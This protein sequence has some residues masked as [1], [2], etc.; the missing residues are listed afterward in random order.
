MAVYTELSDSEIKTLLASYALGEFRQLEGIAEG[1]EN[2]NFFLR[3]MR[4]TYILTIY[5][6]RVN[7]ED[8]PFFLTLM[9]HLASKH[10]PC[11]TPIADNQ[12]TLLQTV[13]GR[14]AAI[15]SFLA[16]KSTKNIRIHHLEALGAQL[17]AMHVAGKDFPLRRA[18]NFSLEC[19]LS[20]FGAVSSRA[21]EVKQGL[22]GEIQRQLDWLQLH[23]PKH[24]PS[25]I[26]HAD[27]F[28]DNV[29]F[30]DDKLSGL[31][32]FYFACN[33]FLAYDLAICMNAWCFEGHGE[34]NI[35]KARAL[36]ASYHSVRPLTEAEL[37]A[38]PALASGAA[39]RF[40]LTRLYDWLNRVEGALVTPKNPL[41]YLQ[42]L[43]FHQGIS[44][45]EAYGI[46]EVPCPQ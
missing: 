10:I 26:I 35:T 38:M 24:L 20:L 9:Q 46:Y 3:T 5:E 45:H 23:W 2:S 4:D 22:A 32:D 31:I 14:P 36:I 11:P 8:L 41:E 18:N 16:G 39:M 17:A 30:Q 27:L 43:R 21:D 40:L 15:V 7:P 12:G 1:V 28:P 37:H 34:L 6:K 19:W 13:K 42:K 44:Q 25:G 33:D 29:F